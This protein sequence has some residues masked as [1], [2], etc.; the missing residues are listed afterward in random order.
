ME[1]PLSAFD[2]QDDPDGE[3]AH[4]L[5]EMFADVSNSFYRTMGLDA[6]PLVRRRH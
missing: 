5:S 2:T 4:N 1:T 6:E 3:I